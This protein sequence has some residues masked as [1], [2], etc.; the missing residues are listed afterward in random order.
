MKAVVQYKALP[1]ED[2]VSLVDTELPTPTISDEDLLVNI[3]AISVNPA[4]TRV[5][6]RKQDDGTHAILG[7]DV[8]GTVVDVGDNVK[9]FTVGD[10]IWYAGDLTRPG[11]NSE[12]HVVN[13]QLADLRPNGLSAEAAAAMPL[14]LLT[15]WE[16]LFN[17]LGLLRDESNPLETLLIIGAAGGAGS[18]CIQIAK[19]IPN[20]QVIA[21]ASRPESMQWCRSL[22]A[23]IV[24]NHHDDIATQL[25][26]HHIKD[27]DY[28]MVLSTPDHYITQLAQLIKPLGKVCSIVPFTEAVDMNMLMY[29]SITFCWEFMFTHSMY[30]TAG[31][32]T[33][34]DILKKCKDLFESGQLKTT[35]TETLSPINAANIRAAH[36]RIKSGNDWQTNYSTTKV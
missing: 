12:Y 15:A 35:L 5:R 16:A 25:T 20:L 1:A 26:Q 28:A 22:G 11:C 23:D 32:A 17:Q 31:Q 18:A 2:K 4:D 30:R 21:T 27:L 33:Q 3:E 10:K 14:T 13:Y 24:I 8:A 6:M 9:N 19:L 7:W 34:G 36:Q 29:K